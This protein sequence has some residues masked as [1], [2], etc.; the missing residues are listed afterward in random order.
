[1]KKLL[2]FTIFAAFCLSA[3]VFSTS[4]QN[5]ST[6]NTANTNST[7]NPTPKDSAKKDEKTPSNN[8]NSKTDSTEKSDKADC[9]NNKLEGKKVLASQTFAIDFKP[10]QKSCFVTFHDPEFTDPPLN[11]QIYIYKDSK[12][13]YDFPQ[14]PDG[15]CWVTGVAFEDLNGDDLT[16]VIVAGMCGA[17]M[18]DYSQNM[19]YANTGEEFTTDSDANSKLEDFTKIKEI[20]DFVK[21]N[22]N[23][24]FK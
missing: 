14:Q 24:F 12:K 6:T 21:K 13:I 4:S 3:C 15:G 8:S 10:F 22:Q 16:D 7:N 5:Q 2:F 20:T 17:K 9:L 1:M 19:V 18:G 23:L 11:S